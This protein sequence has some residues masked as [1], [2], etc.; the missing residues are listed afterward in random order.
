MEGKPLTAFL[1]EVYH[2]WPMTC[3][4]G[5]VELIKLFFEAMQLE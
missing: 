2:L 1:S 3:F 5:S 4:K